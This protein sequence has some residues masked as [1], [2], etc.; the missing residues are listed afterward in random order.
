MKRWFKLSRRVPGWLFV[1]GALLLILG[2]CAQ[3]GSQAPV[4]D[5]A[6]TAPATS[7]QPEPADAS[8]PASVA[9]ANPV[10]NPAAVTEG[11]TAEGDWFRG[12]PNAPVTLI[13]FSDYQCPFCSRHVSQTGPLIEDQYVKTGLVKHVFKDFPLSSIHPQAEKAAEAAHCA[14]AQKQYWACLLYTSPSPR[15]RTRSRMPS[16]A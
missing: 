1:T 3:P 5:K 9:V 6:T 12:D 4:T 11:Q 8:T 13:E 2:A 7:N 10:G 15:D 16:S 14:G